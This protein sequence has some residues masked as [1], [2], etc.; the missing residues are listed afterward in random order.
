MCKI[1]WCNGGGA[2]S[3]NAKKVSNNSNIKPNKSKNI[4]KK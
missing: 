2:T 4:K 1:Y 3:I